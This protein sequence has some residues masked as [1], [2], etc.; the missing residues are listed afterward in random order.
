MHAL[1]NQVLLLFSHLLPSCS[2]QNTLPQSQ[3]KGPDDDT[4]RAAPVFTLAKLYA[5]APHLREYEW[6]GSCGH[7]YNSAGDVNYYYHHCKHPGCPASVR[8]DHGDVPTANYVKLHNHDSGSDVE[9]AF[10][11]VRAGK[12]GARGGA[13]W[14]RALDAAAVH[15]R[16]MPFSTKSCSFSHTSFP[17]VHNKTHRHNQQKGLDNGAAAPTT[18]SSSSSSS[19]SSALRRSGRRTAGNRMLAILEAEALEC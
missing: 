12:G 5:I 16:G 15:T 1:F 19:S 18:G 11:F 10:F 7:V 2:Q 6:G 17:P 14:G 13:C 8:V 3:Q 4:A 9:G